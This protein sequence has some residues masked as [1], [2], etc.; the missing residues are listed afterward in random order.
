M[1]IVTAFMLFDA[2]LITII[3][4]DLDNPVDP[5]GNSTQH[6]HAS[7]PTAKHKREHTIIVFNKLGDSPTI[8]LELHD[9]QIT[10]VFYLFPKMKLQL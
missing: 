3:I 7:Q 8:L 5:V 10:Y 9:R 4:I 1:N 2:R 6:Q